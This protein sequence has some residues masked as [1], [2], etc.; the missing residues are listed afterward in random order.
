M[1]VYTWYTLKKKKNALFQGSHGF[2]K[3]RGLDFTTCPMFFTVK[4]VCQGVQTSSTDIF[5]E[6]DASKIRQK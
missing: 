6:D 5:D 2:F 4:D 3:K 1:Q